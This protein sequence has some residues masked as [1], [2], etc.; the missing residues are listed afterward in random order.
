MIEWEALWSC[1]AG[2]NFSGKAGKVQIGVGSGTG[3]RQAGIVVKR[4]E[5]VTAELQNIL[6]QLRG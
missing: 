6:E 4:E 3:R 2:Q 1:T 5:L